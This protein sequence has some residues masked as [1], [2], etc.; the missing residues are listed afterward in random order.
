MKSRSI[1]FVALDIGSSKISAIAAEVGNDGNASIISQII[2]SSEGIKSSSVIDWKSAENSIL[3]TI[4]ALENDLGV[5]IKKAN[6]SLSGV[7]TKSYYLSSKITLK[8][9][10]VTKKDIEAVIRKAFDKFKIEGYEIIHYFPIEFTLDDSDAI[11]D[12]VGM[13]GQS[14]GC[15]LH[16]VSANSAMLINLANCLSKCHVEISSFVLSSYASGISSLTEDEKDLGAVAI[17]L[18]ARSTSF[19]IFL[20]KKMIYS[21]SIPIGSWHITSDIAKVLSIPFHVA[22][23]VKILHGKALE[24]PADKRIRINLEEMY[25]DIDSSL[26]LLTSSQLIEVIKPRLEEIFTMI[27]EQY[28][29]TGID[30][31]ISNRL[32]LSGGGSQL[33]GSKELASK[34]FNKNVKVTP[35]PSVEGFSEDYNLGAFTVILGMVQDFAARKHKKYLHNSSK[36][37][38]IA[39]RVFSWLKENVS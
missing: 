19:S 18:G 14:L 32:T 9:S 28:D 38:N 17:D 30:H 10:N 12:P 11:M 7:K 35:A 23:R 21:G 39:R 24:E 8:N 26:S 15:R 34:I 27:K 29:K 36:H 3:S 25:P 6:I 13:F 4:Y 37:S 33:Q 5:N 1:D 31:L 2:Q 22:E 16:I 20:S